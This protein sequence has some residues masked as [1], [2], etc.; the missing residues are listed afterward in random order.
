MSFKSSEQRI[1]EALSAAAEN[2]LC[3][4]EIEEVDVLYNE[5]TIEQDC[6]A[7]TDHLRASMRTW[8]LAQ[9]KAHWASETFCE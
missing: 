4:A 2:Y 7:L 5:Q 9:R 6:R 1:D 3:S 8:A